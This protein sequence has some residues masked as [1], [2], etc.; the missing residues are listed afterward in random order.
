MAGVSNKRADQPGADINVVPLIDIVLVLLIIFMVVTPM[1][2]KGVDVKLPKATNVVEKDERTSNDL[3]VAV[4]AD[5]TFWLETT[6]LTESEL[7]T[8]LA[9]IIRA[10]PFRPVQ[11][12]GDERVSFGEVRKIV[13]MAQKAGAKVVN[14]ATEAKKKKAT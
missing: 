10:A 8:A 1:L 14:I 6:Q 12:K 5:G 4:K 3:I 2:S 7:E 9:S 11:V 13:L